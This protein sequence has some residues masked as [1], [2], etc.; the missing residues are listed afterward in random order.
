MQPAECAVEEAQRKQPADAIVTPIGLTSGQPA[1]IPS[2]V[3]VPS[4]WPAA[5]NGVSGGEKEEDD[6][7][8]DDDVVCMPFLTELSLPL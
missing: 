3:P 5:A 2:S 1:D 8:D 4:A 6:D 7:G